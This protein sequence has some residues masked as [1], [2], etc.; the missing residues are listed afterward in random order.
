VTWTVVVR[1]GGHIARERHPGLDE[2]LTAVEAAG[3]GFER[4][5]PPAA[6]DAKIRRFE[7]AEQVV[8]RL[9]LRGPQRLLPDVRAGVDV[10][11]DGRA[12]AWRG[13]VSRRA[14]EPHAGE[15]AYTALRRELGVG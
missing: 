11:G 4:A 8:A 7:P 14:L 10:R 5:A 9:E 6:V 13:R 1:S 2:A 3:R 12:E 15:S